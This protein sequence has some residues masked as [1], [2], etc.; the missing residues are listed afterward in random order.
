MYRRYGK[1]YG[2]DGRG[3]VVAVLDSGVDYNHKDMVISPEIDVKMTEE[4]VNE[5]KNKQM[6]KRGKYFTEKNPIW[7]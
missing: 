1:E 6:E 4:K 2:Y 3:K 5:I 7:L